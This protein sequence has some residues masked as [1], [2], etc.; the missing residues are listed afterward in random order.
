ML[1]ED[2]AANFVNVHKGYIKKIKRSRWT[3]DFFKPAYAQ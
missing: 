1:Y 3:A 2:T